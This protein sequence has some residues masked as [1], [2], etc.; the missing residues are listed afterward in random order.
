M[1]DEQDKPKDEEE[2]QLGDIDAGSSTY[3][4]EEAEQPAESEFSPNTSSG[5]SQFFASPV[6]RNAIIVIV[7]VVFAYFAY[8]IYSWMSSGERATPPKKLAATQNIK[9]FTPTPAPASALKEEIPKVPVEQPSPISN[10]LKAKLRALAGDQSRVQSDLNTVLNNQ[11]NSQQQIQGLASKV[12]ELLNLVNAQNITLQNQASMIR[13]LEDRCKKPVKQVKRHHVRA[14][15]PMPYY[16]QAVIPGRAWLIKRNG[17]DTVTVREG[18][19]LPGYG[20]V[21]LIDPNQGRVITSSGQVITF[22]QWDS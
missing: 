6:N 16:I 12:D 4:S 13:M 17:T 10:E 20:V 14:K 18:T 21:K 15:A 22:G 8:I 3:S 19:R 1:I 9:P 11:N 5:I 7:A 2:Y